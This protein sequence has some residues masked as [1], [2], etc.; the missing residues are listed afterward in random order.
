RSA[1]A[2]EPHGD[3]H[4][5]LPQI[6][7]LP[8]VEGLGLVGVEVA[9]LGAKH[10]HVA[11]LVAPADGM[12]RVGRRETGPLPPLVAPPLVAYGEV[13]AFRDLEHRVVHDAVG[14]A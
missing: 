1:V 3:V 5:E 4:A 6:I 2:S 14:P 8:E 10:E 11:E 7:L 12:A 9:D 13:V